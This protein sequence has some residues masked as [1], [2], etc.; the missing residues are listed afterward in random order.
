MSLHREQADLTRTP[1]SVTPAGW[2]SRLPFPAAVTRVS[3]RYA[4]GVQPN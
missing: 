3:R 1:R 4:P 2:A